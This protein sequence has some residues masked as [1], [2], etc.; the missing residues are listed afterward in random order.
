MRCET[1]G[2]PA[3]VRNGACVFCRTPIRE[4]DAPVELLTYLADHLPLVRTKRFGIIGRGLVRRLDITVDGERFRARAVRG[5]L[6]LEPDLPP[7][8]WVERLLERLS[9]VA[10]ADA[11]VRARLLR[12]GW[13]LR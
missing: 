11:D 1:C 7:A 4:S 5:R 12:A 8:Q 13:A 10:S 9:K 2:A 3:V 6:L